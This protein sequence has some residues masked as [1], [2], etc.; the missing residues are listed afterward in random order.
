M[1]RNIEL[2]EFDLVLGSV[3]FVG[4]WAF[5]DPR[6]VS[7]YEDA[8]VDVLWRSYFGLLEDA[9][10]SGLFDVMSHPD[11]IKKFAFMPSF[12]PEPLYQSA[13]RVFAESG[14]AIE[15]STAGLRKPCKELYPA[16]AFLAACRQAGVPATVSSD[17]H[18]PED[19][20]WGF[21][22]AIDALVDAGYDRYVYFVDRDPI[23]VEIER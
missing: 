14:V 11:L 2:G 19:V 1:R 5:D 21:D 20:G 15:A 22:R 9:A 12:D 8:D 7:R 18:R 13:A 10:A 4:D 23:E 17:A 3:H 6:L 16:P